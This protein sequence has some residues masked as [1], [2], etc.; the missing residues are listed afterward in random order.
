MISEVVTVFCFT[1][2]KLNVLFFFLYFYLKFWEVYLCKESAFIFCYE[3]LLSETVHRWWNLR[4]APERELDD[5]TREVK[6][7][8]DQH[9][10][11]KTLLPC[12]HR[13]DGHLSP[14]SGTFP[15]TQSADNLIC[16]SH[17]LELTEIIFCCLLLNYFKVFWYSSLKR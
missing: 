1:I 4:E 15:D 16:L 14:R 8:R 5:G 7:R 13:E 12:E 17:P 3:V 10:S 11:N 2:V 9:F 6:N